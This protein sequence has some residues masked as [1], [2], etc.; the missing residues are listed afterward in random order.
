[1]H[2]IFPS[3]QALFRPWIKNKDTSDNFVLMQLTF[4]RERLSMNNPKRVYYNRCWKGKWEWVRNS[5][6][7]CTCIYEYVGYVLCVWISTCLYICVDCVHMWSIPWV[8]MYVRSVCIWY[9][10]DICWGC[11]IYTRWIW[12]GYVYMCVFECV[13]HAYICRVCVGCVHTRMYMCLVFI[14]WLICWECAIYICMCVGIVHAYVVMY[15]LGVHI[16]IYMV[17]VHKWSMY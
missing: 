10:Q 16:Y 2:W 3:C 6:R 7:P 11:Y 8:H 14:M 13:W 12:V 4:K 9:M 17:Y 15:M 5:A 1:M